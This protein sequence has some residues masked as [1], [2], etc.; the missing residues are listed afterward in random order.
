[1]G[2]AQALQVSTA[3]QSTAHGPWASH[4]HQQHQT[5][6]PHSPSAAASNHG[7]APADVGHAPWHQPPKSL[8]V[9]P[10]A[11]G[12]MQRQTNSHAEFLSPGGESVAAPSP[13]AH[14]RMP[15][16][17]YSQPPTPHSS[18]A[19]APDT[20]PTQAEP[21]QQG[22]HFPSLPDPGSDVSATLA[23]AAEGAISEPEG[24]RTVAD[25]DPPDTAM[26]GHFGGAGRTGGLPPKP[27][28]LLTAA[29]EGTP[30]VGK[31]S[32]SGSGGRW[33]L[34]SPGSVGGG[35]SWAGTPIRAQPSMQDSHAS[36]A[37]GCHL[38]VISLRE[39]P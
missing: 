2:G 9:Q 30:K 31:G 38:S 16:L 18:T 19:V 7:A 14:H 12:P 35:S 36:A 15:T 33:G 37:G 25:R 27:P 17:P 6:Y 22:P 20:G 11:H 34:V 3:Q 8:P 1:M 23:S 24:T 26:L 32:Q 29:V 13:A 10:A 21:S 4:A 28:A 39:G 5:P